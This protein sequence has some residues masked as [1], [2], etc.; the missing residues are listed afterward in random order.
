MSCKDSTLPSQL[1]QRPGQYDKIRAAHEAQLKERESQDQV[2]A[3]VDVGAQGYLL[4][5]LLEAGETPMAAL[6]RLKPNNKKR[7]KGEKA[8]STPFDLVTETTDTLMG[9][10]FY[11]ASYRAFFLLSLSFFLS[12]SRGPLD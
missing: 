9:Q 6:K 8:P 5:S 7:K 3:G 2:D 11:G 10:G 1:S 4:L 12:V